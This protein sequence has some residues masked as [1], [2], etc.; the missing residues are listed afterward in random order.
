MKQVI[1]GSFVKD[2]EHCLLLLILSLYMIY[3]YIIL[4]IYN[5]IYIY[6]WERERWRERERLIAT[7]DLSSNPDKA[8]TI[9]MQLFSPELW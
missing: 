9:L 5:Y 2:N 3:L 7:F 4:Y 6:I 8:G 1:Q